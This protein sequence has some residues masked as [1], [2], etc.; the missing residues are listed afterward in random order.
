MNNSCYSYENTSFILIILQQIL[1]DVESMICMETLVG[2]TRQ[3]GV[4][5]QHIVNVE[6]VNEALDIM[7]MCHTENN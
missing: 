3:M 4:K 6:K 2:K 5:F 1:L 7:T